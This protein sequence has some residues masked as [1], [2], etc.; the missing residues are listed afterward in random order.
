MTYPM[1][2][3]RKVAKKKTHSMQMFHFIH[4]TATFYR[5]RNHVKLKMYR[6][7]LIIL[8]CS[9]CTVFVKELVQKEDEQVKKKQNK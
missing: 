6:T 2:N 9:Q 3:M 7:F 5:K 8:L 4:S 1:T